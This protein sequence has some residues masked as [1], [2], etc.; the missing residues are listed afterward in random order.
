[1]FSTFRML[2]AAVLLARDAKERAVEM[3]ADASDSVGLAEM[4]R[5][6]DEVTS[7]DPRIDPMDSAEVRDLASQAIAFEEEL[8]RESC[9]RLRASLGA[10]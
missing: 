10:F 6:W 4:E 9:H 5:V 8:T 7:L 1:M 3:L 2:R